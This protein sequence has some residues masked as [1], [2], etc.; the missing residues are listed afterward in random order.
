[1][2]VLGKPLAFVLWASKIYWRTCIW[3]K[4]NIRSISVI[5]QQTLKWIFFHLFTWYIFRLYYATFICDSLGITRNKGQTWTIVSLGA[6][7]LAARGICVSYGIN[8]FFRSGVGNSLYAT[9][10]LPLSYARP[11]NKDFATALQRALKN[12]TS[13]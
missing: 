8:T 13:K 1:M 5:P 11:R 6:P 12:C 3:D 7:N 10:T 9:K 4:R 2:K